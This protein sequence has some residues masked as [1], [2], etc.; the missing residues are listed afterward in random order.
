MFDI[1]DF[2]KQLSNTI[3]LSFCVADSKNNTIFVS[4]NFNENLDMVSINISLKNSSFTIKLEKKNE[5]SLKLL[6]YTIENYYL[7][8]HSSKEQYIINLLEGKDIPDNLILEGIPFLSKGCHVLLINIDKNIDEALHIINEAYLNEEVFGIIYKGNILVI[9]VFEEVLEH[10]IGIKET[11]TLNLFNK[12]Y[13]S[14]SNAIYDKNELKK[15]YLDCKINML[16][17]KQFKVRED[18]YSCSNLFFEKLI[19]NTDFNYKKE[20]QLNYKGIF[21]DFDNELINTLE[22][23]LYCNLNISIAAK[24]LYI[25]RN[26]LIY[27]LDKIKKETGF[28]IRIFNEAMAFYIVL[29]V[30]KESK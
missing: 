22:Q 7:K 3:D 11:I 13:I 21:N 25:H 27:R 1:N 18:I 15:A 8:L 5:A 9:G 28:D 23:F 29:L 19:Y 6:K 26:T 4:D 24:K 14:F 12:C 16:I 17:G 30:W 10:V 20:L 2:L